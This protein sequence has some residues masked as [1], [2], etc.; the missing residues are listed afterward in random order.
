MVASPEVGEKG[1]PH[2]QFYLAFKK[3]VT[4][5]HVSKALNKQ[6]Y[7]FIKRG[8]CKQASDYCLKGKMSW[9]KGADN[10]NDPLFGI[11]LSVDT[12]VYGE[13]PAEQHVAG[14]TAKEQIWADNI[15]LMLAGRGEEMTPSHQVLHYKKYEELV[16]RL[17]KKPDRLTWKRGQSPNLWIYGP[18]G[19]GKSHKARELYPDLYE[20]MLNKWWEHYDQQEEILLEDVGMSHAAWIGDFIKIWADIYPF[21][22]EAKFGSKML[23][24]KVIIV[25]SNY[26][27]EELFPDPNVHLPIMDRFQLMHLTEKY[28]PPEDMEPEG[29]FVLGNPIN[30]YPMFD[31]VREIFAVEDAEDIPLGPMP[32]L[33]DTHPP[34]VYVDLTNRRH[35]S[36]TGESESS[37][38][39]DEESDIDVEK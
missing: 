18:T 24:P 16:E 2:I 8:T 37:D 38:E 3:K 11:G 39:V 1:T 19:T 6:A 4:F 36:D 29:G 26:H 27:P 5:V 31:V 35:P 9:V 32:R 7:L 22:N 33:G 20:K 15:V 30:N 13:L 34:P 17:Q 28:V 23:R 25:T 14:I 21:R 10:A 12:I